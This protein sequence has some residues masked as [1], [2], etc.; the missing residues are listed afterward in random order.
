MAK[1]REALG[2]AAFEAGRYPTAASIFAETAS[3]DE[4]TDF[5]TLPAYDA[6]RA[7]A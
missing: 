3:S 1:I 4:L 5:L 2:Q 7:L 6:L